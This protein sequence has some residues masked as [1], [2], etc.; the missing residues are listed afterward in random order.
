[1]P[2]CRQPP[3]RRL[4][5][6]RAWAMLAAEL[7]STEPT[8]APRPLEKQTLTVS[9]RLPYAVQRDPGGH[10][11]VPE[12]GAVQV[13]AETLGRHSSPSVASRSYGW[14]VPPPKLWVFSTAT[15]AVD[16]R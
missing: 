4:R 14:I 15:A 13:V 8:G 12:P 2:A 7:A 9:N 1:M 10:V 5:Q 6:I 16:T 3:P 11:R